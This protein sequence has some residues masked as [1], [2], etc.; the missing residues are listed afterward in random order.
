MKNRSIQQWAIVM[1]CVPAMSAQTVNKIEATQAEFERQLDSI[2]HRSSL[3]FMP[4]FPDSR[5]LTEADYKRISEEAD[6]EEAAIKA[7]VEI[8]SGKTHNGFSPTGK[9]LLN[10]DLSLFKKKLAK[11]GINLNQARKKAPVAFMPPDTK[12]FGSYSDA[13]HARFEAARTISEKAAIES[14]FWGLFQIGGFNWSK[15]GLDSA[16]EFIELMSRSE[17]DQLRL[18]INFLDRNGMLNLIRTKNWSAFAH[19]YNGPGYKRRG[20]DRR[21]AAAY[22]K[23][24][25]VFNK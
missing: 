8:E 22:K 14:T 23:Y 5:K 15:C 7:V 16:D 17:Q 3:V 10:F 19:R 4:E 21:L 12:R 18:F 25:R 13:Q 9:P 24:K 11:E 20:Y 2:F 6:I 1:M